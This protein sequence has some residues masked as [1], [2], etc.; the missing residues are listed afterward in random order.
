ME[1]APQTVEELDPTGLPAIAAELAPAPAPQMMAREPVGPKP[2]CATKA[3]ADAWAAEWWAAYEADKTRQH[4]G[5][6]A[7]TRAMYFEPESLYALLEPGPDGT[8]APVA[9]LKGSYLLQRANELR[10]A[11]GQSERAALRLP[12]RQ[13]LDADAFLTADEVRRLGRGQAGY[14]FE[15]CFP[16]RGEGDKP[17]KLVSISH[18]WLTAD[19]LRGIRAHSC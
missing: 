11:A 18:G 13:D 5:K 7:H 16:C 2:R 9:L 4:G 3:E 6:G 10:A 17:L 8:P 1:M 12:R 19:H 15:T 14:L